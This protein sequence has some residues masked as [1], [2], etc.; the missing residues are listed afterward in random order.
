MYVYYSYKVYINKKFSVDIYMPY[1]EN[2][3]IHGNKHSYNYY[4]YQQNRGI[5]PHNAI[6]TL[7]HLRENMRLYSTN[8]ENT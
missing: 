8:L 3:V 4:K 5:F 7:F 1:A 6:L 2:R